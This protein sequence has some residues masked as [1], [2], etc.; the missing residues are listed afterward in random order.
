MSPSLADS[1]LT[2][3]APLSPAKASVLILG[4]MP[5]SISLTQ[6]QYYAHPRNAF[7]PIMAQLCGFEPGLP[8]NA[9]VQQ[10]TRSG[11]ALWDVI[12]SCQRDGS[13]DSAIRAEQVNDF[14]SFFLSQSLL[15]A[16]GF[17]GVKAWQSF[18]RHVLVQQIVPPKLSLIV[19]PS[20]SPAHAA[21]N[22]SDKLQQW[23]Q[24]K[25]FLHSAN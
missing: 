21:L 12:S 25:P 13:L 10:L 11:V 4:S 19:L 5:G 24:L 23:Q 6:Q 14:S 20:T 8:Y 15:A 2:G 18:K 17:N 7:W 16:V 3:L 22:V 9:R 1:R